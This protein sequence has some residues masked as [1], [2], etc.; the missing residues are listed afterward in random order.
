MLIKTAQIQAFSGAQAGRFVHETVA[1]LREAEPMWVA[2]KSKGEI[3]VQIE[4]FIAFA[5]A[6]RIRKREAVNT[7]IEAFIRH[8][9]AMPLDDRLVNVLRQPNVSESARAEQ[10]YIS[11]ASGRH[12]LKEIALTP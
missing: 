12:L 4:E 1:R 8:K 9:P 7:V 3:G 11:L 2:G 5:A 10:F 6:S